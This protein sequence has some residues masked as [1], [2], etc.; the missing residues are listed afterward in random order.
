[1]C[2]KL[3]WLA[4]AVLVV[5]I[6]LER[7]VRAD[8]PSLLGWWKLDEGSGETVIDSSGR[9]NDGTIHNPLGGLGTG[10][11]VWAYDAQRGLVASFSGNDSSGAYITTTAMIPFL[12]LESDF[13]WAFWAKQHANQPTT[14]PGSGNDVMLGNRYGGTATPL[15]FVKFTPGKFEYYNDDGAYLMAIDYEDMPGGK[16]VHCVGVKKGAALTY[17]RNGVPAGTAALTKTM[18]PNPFYM[19]GDAQGERWQGWLS[20]VRLYERALSPEEIKAL[21]ETPVAPAIKAWNPT[22]ANGDQA[23]QV[24][25]FQWSAPSTSLRHNLYVGTTPE[26]TE[27]TVVVSGLAP[28][29]YFHGTGL[30]PGQSYSWRVDEVEGNGTVHTG[31]VWTF[32]MQALTAY[33]PDPADGATDASTTPMLVWMPGQGVAK[34]HVYFS[35]SADEVALGAAAADKGEVPDPNFAPGELQPATRYSWRVD[36]VSPLAVVQAGPVWH[37]TTCLPVDDFESYND[38]EGKNTRIYETWIDGYADGS[39]GSTVGNT[40]PPFAEQKIVH[41]GL[42][43]MPLDYNNVNSPFYS[44]AVRE[45]DPEQDWTIN[46]VNMLVLYIQGRSSNSAA[47]LYVIL[48]DA[49]RHTTVVTHPDLAVVS[50]AKWVEWKIPLTEFTDVNPARIKKLYLGVGDK[51]DPKKGGTGRVYVD[52]FRVIKPVE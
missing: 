45:F 9:G 14:V 19:G 20:D 38:E 7:P 16:W 4:V 40:E 3:V 32:T 10:N 26:L 13:T 42:Q 31:T 12:G 50:R 52:D 35:E 44:E 34:H 21:F 11:A 36:E 8:D 25:L 2:K 1:M 37:F 6:V 48:E 17:Y 39:S 29:F 15:Q 18:D 51:A 22:P 27:P 23:V 47:P 28:T 24:A 41:G 49:A 30:T 5:N 33:L 43:S 46:D